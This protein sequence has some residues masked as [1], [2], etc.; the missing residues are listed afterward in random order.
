VAILADLPLGASKP[1]SF[2]QAA[3]QLPSSW[4]SVHAC[5]KGTILQSAP[6]AKLFST[7]ERWDRDGR[8]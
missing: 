5:M 7:A 4:R 3:D 2:A 8:S 6:A 1:S